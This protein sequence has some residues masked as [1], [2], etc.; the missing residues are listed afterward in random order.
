MVENSAWTLLQEDPL[1]GW[2]G[3]LMAPGFC[4]GTDRCCAVLQ[5]SINGPFLDFL[6]QLV[7]A[8]GLQ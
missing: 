1:P 5:Y 6:A 3:A 2:D 8:S 7:P 4:Q